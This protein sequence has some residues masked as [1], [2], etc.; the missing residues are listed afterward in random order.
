MYLITIVN[1]NRPAKFYAQDLAEV[2]AVIKEYHPECSVVENLPAL[3][4]LTN[5]HCQ[6]DSNGKEVENE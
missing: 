3:S 6:T 1:N 4:E 2:T 5:L